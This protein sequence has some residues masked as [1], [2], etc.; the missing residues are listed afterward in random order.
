MTYVCVT[1]NRIDKKGCECNQ[2]KVCG[3]RVT[4][5]DD[6][7]ANTKAPIIKVTMKVYP[8]PIIEVNNDVDGECTEAASREE[9]DNLEHLKVDQEDGT[10]SK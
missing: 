4:A 7:E 5:I 1:A 3:E 2:N 6:E 9:I 10:Y 8:K